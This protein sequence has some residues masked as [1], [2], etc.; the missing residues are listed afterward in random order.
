MKRKFF[1]FIRS[2]LTLLDNGKFYRKTFGWFYASF[3]VAFLMSPFFFVVSTIWWNNAYQDKMETQKLYQEV[4]LPEFNTAKYSTDT[5]A[6]TVESLGKEMNNAI[7]CLTKATKQADYYGEYA[8]YGPEYQQIYNNSLDIKRQWDVAYQEVADRWDVTNAQLDV[9]KAKLAKVK[10]RYDKALADYQK[11][12]DEFELVNQLGTV[13][14][15]DEM[16]KGNAIAALVLFSFMALLVGAL[17]F[18]LWWSR[19][20]DLKT[21]LK[22]QDKFLATP[23]ASHFIQTFGES[24]GL[25][26]CLWGFFSALIFFTC[27]LSIG[28]MG[29]NFTNLGVI[30]IFIPIVVGFL[31]AFVFRIVAELLKALVFLANNKGE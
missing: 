5:L 29:F 10:I 14:T 22:V 4:L 12:K 9:F 15:L 18:L 1:S 26:V 11:A 21:L 24:L 19:M 13:F 17:N 7:D 31:I 6:R 8:S 28:Q 23:V 2:S 20:L 27:N 3:A 30:S 16:K 25:T